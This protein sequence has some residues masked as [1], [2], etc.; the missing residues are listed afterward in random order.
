MH[1]RI[2]LFHKVS[3]LFDWNV[4]LTTEIRGKCGWFDSVDLVWRVLTIMDWTANIQR[5]FLGISIP[6]KNP[7]C[8]SVHDEA[9]SGIYKCLDERETKC[10]RFLSLVDW[11]TIGWMTLFKLVGRELSFKVAVPGNTS[12]SKQERWDCSKWLSKCSR[13][14]FQYRLWFTSE[15]NW[16]SY[17]LNSPS[18]RYLRAKRKLHERTQMHNK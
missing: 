13:D 12:E 18:Y 7:A 10:D 16:S 4:R 3:Y 15:G 9:I 6:E 2:C 8:C 1:P 17:V 11:Q 14:R 5:R